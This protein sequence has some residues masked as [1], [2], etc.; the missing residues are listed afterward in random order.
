MWGAPLWQAPTLLTNNQQT[1]AN[2][3]AY[4]KGVQH[5]TATEKD[6]KNWKSWYF[7]GWKTNNQKA[8]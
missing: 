2:A 3:L 5:P 6:G 1:C 4:N 7:F 8:V